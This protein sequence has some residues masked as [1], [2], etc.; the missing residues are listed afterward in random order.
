MPGTLIGILLAVLCIWLV[1]I[2]I[3]WLSFEERVIEIAGRLV[4]DAYVEHLQDLIYEKEGS[5]LEE[6]DDLNVGLRLK[7]TLVSTVAFMLLSHCDADMNV[8]QGE[9]DF[10][11]I[12]QFNTPRSLSVMGNAAAG[13]CKPVLMEIGRAVV[14]SERR[15]EKSN[16]HN[17][18]KE[19][20]NGGQ[21]FNTLLP[22]LL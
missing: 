7:E 18:A 3:K 6:L 20:V 10:Q 4:Q 14:Q 5:F 17:K 12:S 22:I 13:L 15:K 11:Y 1:A 21:G 9:L 16:A 8:W 2:F 19:H